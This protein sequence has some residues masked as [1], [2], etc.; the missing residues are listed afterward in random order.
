MKDQDTDPR[1]Y[2]A[3]PLIAVSIALFRDDLVLLI[4]R[5]K[6]PFE[7][8]FSFPGGLV[9]TG[10]LL[11]DAA[12]RE[13]W[14]ELEMKAGELTFNRHLEMVERDAAGRV[15]RHFVVASFAGRWA[16]GDGRMSDEVSE[17]LWTRTPDLSGLLL[18]PGLVGVIASARRLSI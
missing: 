10:E 15:K 11:Q 3:R 2:P 5:A 18:T 8:M 6:P 16:S 13:L 4:K 9:E 17:I 14:E 1:L 12:R 7:N